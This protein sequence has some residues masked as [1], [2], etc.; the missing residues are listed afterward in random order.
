VLPKDNVQMIRQ[1]L[2]LARKELPPDLIRLPVAAP[3][4]A[5]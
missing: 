2:R 5:R 1:G 3:E 4:E